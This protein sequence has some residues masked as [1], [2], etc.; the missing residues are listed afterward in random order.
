VDIVFFGSGAFGVPTLASLAE[1][2][3]LIAVVSQPDRRAGR[4]DHDRPTPCAGW[5]EFPA[6]GIPVLKPERVNEPAVVAELRTLRADAW[7]VVAF[8]Q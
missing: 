4:G 1:R 8:G 3:R 5:A 7:V 2:H 6:R